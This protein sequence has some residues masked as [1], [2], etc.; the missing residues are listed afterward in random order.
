MRTRSRELCRLAMTVL[1]PG[2]EGTAPPDWLRRALA[3]GLGGAVLF[4]RN[5]A[6]PAQTAEL[7]AAMR[8]E[9]PG[10]IVAVDEEGGAITRL[11]ARTGSSWP[12]NLALGVA[13]DVRATARV[14]RQ[15]GRMLGAADITMDYAPVVD[16]NADPRNPVIGVRSFGSDPER[17]RRHAV[18]WIEGLQGA[19]VAACAKHFPGHGD[20]VTDSHLALPEVRASREVLERRDLPPFRAAIKAGVR[21][22]MCGHLLV[23]ALDRS[24]VTLSRAVLTGLLREELG[25]GGLTVTDAIEMRAVAALQTPEEITVHA[26]AAGAD[27][28]CVGVSSPGGESVYAL[29]DAIVS[30][31]REGRVPEARL[32]EAAGRVL[33][34][35]RWHAEQAPARAAAARDADEGVGLKTATAALRVIGTPG[36]PMLRV[37][38][39]VVE[40]T[41]RPSQAVGRATAVGVGAAIGEIMPG[42]VVA[43]VAEGEDLPD[44]TDLRRPVVVVVRDATRHDW[45]QRLLARALEVRPDA[46]VVETGVPGTPAGA[47]YLATHGGSTVS[48]RAA[49]RRLTAI[50]TQEHA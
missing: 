26:L 19:G 43:E 25:F 50:R 44:L 2:F 7:V 6:G 14:A 13:D 40:M 1:Q 10:V 36:R 49:A 4:T 22:I 24:P 18:A 28:I 46:V 5:L 23:P 38:P 35:A 21:A 8:E 41:T 3:E 47:V 30:A 12:G 31:V 33:E 34:L 45:I 32:A 39:L 48:A 27:A 37:A 15:I 16:V 42:T 20:T 11:E 9:N 17:V 29:R